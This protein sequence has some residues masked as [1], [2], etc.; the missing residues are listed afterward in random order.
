MIFRKPESIKA[1][2]DIMEKK[3][4]KEKMCIDHGVVNYAY[5]RYE[6]EEPCCKNNWVS[7]IYIYVYDF[8]R[9]KTE[10]L[11]M[12]LTEK[13]LRKPTKDDWYV[14]LMHCSWDK[15]YPSLLEIREYTVG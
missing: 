10:I 4:G 8:D 14:E 15:R 7:K 11:D 6:Y 13:N 9:N 1:R 5:S 2:L 12:I 3:I